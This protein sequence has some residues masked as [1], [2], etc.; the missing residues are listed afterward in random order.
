MEEEEEQE[1]EEEE[2]EGVEEFRYDPKNQTPPAEVTL[3]GL[4]KHVVTPCSLEP[5]LFLVLCQMNS[6]TH[7]SFV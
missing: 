1:E 4:S 7:M 6:V 2:E 5:A 3:V